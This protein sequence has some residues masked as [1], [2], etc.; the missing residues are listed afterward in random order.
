MYN[1]FAGYMEKLKNKKVF[2]VNVK[3]FKLIV[4]LYSLKKGF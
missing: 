1:V 2:F 3:H 4:H